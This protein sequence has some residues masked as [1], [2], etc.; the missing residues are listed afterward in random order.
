MSNKQNNK[1][2]GYIDLNKGCKIDLKAPNNYET[3]YEKVES[4][5][6]TQ[7]QKDQQHKIL[8]DRSW[9]AAK[10]PMGSVFMNLFMMWMMG[11]SLHIFTIFMLFSVL[12]GPI[13]ALMGVNETFAK[14]K[15]KGES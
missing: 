12:S 10:A 13:K 9:S 15:I 6:Q 8:V 4:S 5:E 1:V 7:K 11:N 14:L 2:D 3:R